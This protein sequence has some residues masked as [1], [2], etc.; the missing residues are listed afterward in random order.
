MIGSF[1]WV[2]SFR[3]LVKKHGVSD[4]AKATG[5]NRESLYKAVNGK[6]KTRCETFFKR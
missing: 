3:S 2:T 5:L 4:I 6:T 1:L